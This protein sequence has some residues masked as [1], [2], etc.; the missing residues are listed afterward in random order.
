MSNE[1]TK[2]LSAAEAVVGLTSPVYTV[3]PI[4][5]TDIVKYAGAGGDFN[6]IHH[7]EAWAV[8]IGLPSI[9]SMGLFQGGLSSR[10][11]SDWIGLKNLTS[12]GTRF[13]SQVWPGEV[14]KIQGELTEV[15]SG[16]EGTAVKA[17][18]TVT[19]EDGTDV[20]I[21]AWATGVLPR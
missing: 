17:K 3:G 18:I 19:N 1:A 13:R 6:P 4:T 12:F 7:D 5:R 20:K 21:Q 14:L 9:F 11:A 10:L 2:P 15:E 16:P 8:S